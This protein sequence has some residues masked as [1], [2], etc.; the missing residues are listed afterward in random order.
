MGS[1]RS[2]RRESHLKC[3][4]SACF[5]I[6][7]AGLDG[8]ERACR[9]LDF[10]IEIVPE[11]TCRFILELLTELPIFCDSARGNLTVMVHNFGEG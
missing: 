1:D 7:L 11:A 5:E 2:S 9:G 3:H 10:G 6:Y 8:H 4:L